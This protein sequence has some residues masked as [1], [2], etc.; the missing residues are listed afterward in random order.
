MDARRSKLDQPL[1]P[2]LVNELAVVL[3]RHER[4]S[5]RHTTYQIC[6]I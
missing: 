5:I 4:I 1:G 2:E 3:V 6:L